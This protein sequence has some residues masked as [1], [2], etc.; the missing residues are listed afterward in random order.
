MKKLLFVSSN[1]QEVF[2][3]ELAQRLVARSFE[4]WRFY[5][6]EARVVHYNSGQSFSLLKKEV[7]NKVS[8]IDMIR[9]SLALK[10]HLPQVDGIHYHYIDGFVGMLDLFLY[11]LSRK[12]T[13]ATFWGSD[14][15]KSSQKTRLTRRLLLAK[16][17]CITFTNALTQQDFNKNYPKYSNKTL[18]LRFGLIPL[19]YIPEVGPE[20]TIEMRKQLGIPQDKKLVV[21]GTN[22]SPNQN[23]LQIIETL[24]KMDRSLFEKLHFLIPLGYPKDAKTYIDQIAELIPASFRTFFTLDFG[25]YNGKE[26]AVYRSC[27]DILIQLQSTD[28]FS[29]AMQEVMACGK[30]VITASWLPYDLLKDKKVHFYQ[31]D[32][33]ADLTKQL[34]EVVQKPIKPEQAAHNAKII[35]RLSHWEKVILDWVALYS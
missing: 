30:D 5:T 6:L 17:Q 3:G 29:G 1:P 16:A 25:F 21:I 15:Y 28:Q 12:R 23:H 31:I 10:K 24:L 22:A 14:Y 18:T 2:I 4:V 27:T 32:Q 35:N 20:Q 33:F 26:L 19:Q 11:P 34:A 13:I 7:A 9:A 8:L